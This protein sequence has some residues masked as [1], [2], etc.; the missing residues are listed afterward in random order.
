MANDIANDER[1]SDREKCKEQGN[2]YVDQAAM[3]TE[4]LANEIAILI[5]T[6]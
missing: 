3:A 5:E 6:Y 4:T 2:N 1:M